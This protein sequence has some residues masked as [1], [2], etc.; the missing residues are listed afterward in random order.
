MNLPF[1]DVTYTAQNRIGAL[2]AVAVGGANNSPS[3][4]FLPPCR[5]FIDEPVRNRCLVP[6]VSRLMIAN[7]GT[8]FFNVTQ[9]SDGQT[10]FH[11]SRG[12][13]PT[14]VIETIHFAGSSYGIS[15]TLFTG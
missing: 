12:Q 7:L 8:H 13:R 6:K 11:F 9:T 3:V 10:G 1:C 14:L 5:L 4:P 2:F 15:K